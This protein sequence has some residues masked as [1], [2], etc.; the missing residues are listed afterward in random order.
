ML[1]KVQHQLSALAFDGTLRAMQIGQ[2]LLA[3]P[4]GAPTAVQ[5]GTNLPGGYLLMLST[6]AAEPLRLMALSAEGALVL[7]NDGGATWSVAR[8]KE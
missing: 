1:Q 8:G 6:T 5:V 2:G 7:S 4:A 3:W